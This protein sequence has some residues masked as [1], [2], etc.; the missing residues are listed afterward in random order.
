[1]NIVPRTYRDPSD[2]Q[3]MCALLQTG[4]ADQATNTYYAHPGD[5]NWWLFDWLDG[6]NPW[7]NIYLWDDPADPERLLGWGLF[8][9]WGAFDVFVQ[10]ELCDSPWAVDVN[11]WMAER[12]AEEARKQ[13]HTYL[14]RMNVAETD[15][16]LRKQLREHGFQH[17]PEDMLAMRCSLEHELPQPILPEGYVV[18]TVEESSVVSRAAA[19]HAAFQSGTPMQDYLQ[20][21]HHFMA[22][23]GYPTGCDWVVM[24]PDGCAAAF[25]IAW[26][27]SA[28]RIGQ[29]EPVGAHPDYQRK[30]LGKAVIL[31]GM[32]H[33]QSLGMRSVRICVLSDNPAAIKLYEG[34]GFRMVNKLLLHQKAL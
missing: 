6:Q 13:G 25:C 24:T 34:V 31:A 16:G 26:P 10:P 19:Q 23:P 1:M 14:R 32:R 15:K 21:Y 5:L 33:L 2:L 9:P 7:Q 29:I 18:R 17:V 28:S 30:G 3:K 22:S 20:T 12:S 8:F 4:C 11:T 27:D